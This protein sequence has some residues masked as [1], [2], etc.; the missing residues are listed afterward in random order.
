MAHGSR[1]QA[2]VALLT[3]IPG[4]LGEFVLAIY[5]Y[6]SINLKF[7]FPEE[8]SSHRSHGK[9]F[10]KLTAVA[11]TQSFPSPRPKRLSE[12]RGV[13]LEGVSDLDHQEDIEGCVHTVKLSAKNTFGTQ[14][15][16][17]GIL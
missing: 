16:N 6:G 9:S 15:I 2:E 17:L 3:T 5:K 7:W 13:M 4:E 1:N 8:K 14:M 11:A 12:R 10:I